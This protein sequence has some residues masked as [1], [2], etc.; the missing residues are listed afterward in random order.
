MEDLRKS[1]E[2]YYG[3][4][5]R[6]RVNGLGFRKNKLLMVRHRGIGKT[7]HL[8]IPPG[9]GMEFGESARKALHREIREE[10]GL[11]CKVGD[12]LFVFEFLDPPFHAVELFFLVDV[13][14]TQ[15]QPGTD[16]EMELQIIEEVRFLSEEEVYR[17]KPEELHNLFTI[18]KSFEDILKL[19]GYVLFP[20]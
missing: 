17:T 10:T 9:G 16:P 12:F 5:T 6:I 20:K 2:E 15:I 13:T 19:N 14:E 4:R 18:C 7:G 1:L 8:W 3:N 11:N